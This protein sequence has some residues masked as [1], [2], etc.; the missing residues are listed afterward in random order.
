[1]EGLPSN[2]LFFIAIMAVLSSLARSLLPA[3]AE[4]RNFI[5]WILVISSF[6]SVVISVSYGKKRTVFYVPF[7]RLFALNRFDLEASAST[8]YVVPCHRIRSRRIY[9]TNT[10][11]HFNWKV[12]KF[13]TFSSREFLLRLHRIDRSLMYSFSPWFLPGI[14]LHESLSII[15]NKLQPLFILIRKLS[16]MRH[17]NLGV[18]LISDIFITFYHSQDTHVHWEPSGASVFDGVPFRQLQSSPWSSLASRRYLRTFLPSQVLD[19]RHLSLDL[20]TLLQ[21]SDRRKPTRWLK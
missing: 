15:I 19:L 20:S 3:A 17:C 11:G 9:S 10:P 5:L 13:Y 1:M 12:S 8:E 7:D 14:H 6:V 21:S 2:S 18:W 16:F 4:I